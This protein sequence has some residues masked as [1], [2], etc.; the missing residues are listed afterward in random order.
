MNAPAIPLSS[1]RTESVPNALTGVHAV[2]LLAP[3]G[4]SGARESPAGADRR[5]P[6]RRSTDLPV[7]SD[8]TSATRTESTSL[9]TGWGR[10]PTDTHGSVV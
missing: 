5:L 9:P 10:R 4:G 6:V 2:S 7:G 1:L 8:V 3:A